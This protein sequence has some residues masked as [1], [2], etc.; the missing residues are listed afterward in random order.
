VEEDKV[1]AINVSTG[2]DGKRKRNRAIVKKP[3][4]QFKDLDEFESTDEYEMGE[5]EQE[6]SPQ[7]Q[8]QKLMPIIPN[9]GEEE[10]EEGIINDQEKLGQSRKKPVPPLL[11]LDAQLPG[12]DTGAKQ[13]SDEENVNE[14]DADDED[15][16]SCVHQLKVLNNIKVP[17]FVSQ[18]D[19]ADGTMS[20]EDAGYF[21][22]SG[23]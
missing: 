14:Q 22:G 12:R 4:G 10:E 2:I 16:E 21:M 17:P 23:T 19:N 7:S 8:K 1:P 3:K 20:D 15:E 6:E 11:F 9:R 18:C 5:E 13:D